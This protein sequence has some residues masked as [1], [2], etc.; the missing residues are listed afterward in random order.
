MIY[1]YKALL[2][3]NKNF[4]RVYE[5]KAETTLYAF[6]LFLQND[7]SFS[8]DQQVFF[9]TTDQ[10]G[11]EIHEYGLF[12]LGSGSMDQV[13]LE[14]LHKNGVRELHYLFDVFK[15]RYLTLQFEG[16]EDEL[17]RK[18][19]PRTILQRGENPDQFREVAVEIDLNVEI[20][21]DK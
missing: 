11:K 2:P 5:V 13:R 9:R 1:Q 19:Y 18:T 10:T 3:N 4:V 21:E 8:P 15:G 7:L 14:S 16:E 20:I 17:F 12:D 6:H